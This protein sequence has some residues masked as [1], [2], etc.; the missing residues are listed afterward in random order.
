MI[1]ASNLPKIAA[2]TAIVA[3]GVYRRVRR[4]IGRQLLTAARQYVRMGLFTVLCLALTFVR[5]LQPAAVAYIASGLLV[6]AAIGWFAL[7]HTEFA[8][9]PEG[10]FYTPHL[11]IG[12]AIT[13]LF[14]GRLLYRVV[15]VYGRV[16]DAAPGTVP[17]ADNNP[18][19]LG[20]LFLTASYYIV[21]CTGL[22]RWLRNAQQT[23]G[24]KLSSG[25]P[26]GASSTSV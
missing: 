24:D 21:Y 4:N 2:V 7:R 13:A 10:Y 23:A 16:A 5:P 8:A 25:A 9:T 15:L 1:D 26:D 22:L 14:I 11:Y 18:L 19:T 20:I 17:T 12:L 3:F 6:G